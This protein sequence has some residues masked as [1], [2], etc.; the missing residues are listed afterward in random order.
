MEFTKI[1]CLE[2]LFALL[3]KGIENILEHN[4]SQPDFPMEPGQIKNYMTKWL[5]FSAIW[6]IGGSMNLSIRSDFSNKLA[7]FTDIETP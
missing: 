2:A 4:E 7:E 6:E 3:R 1:R 5:V